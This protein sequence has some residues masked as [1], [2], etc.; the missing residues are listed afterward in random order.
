[1]NCDV[2]IVGAGLVGASLAA[3]LIGSGLRVLM[4]DAQADESPPHS[5][6]DSRIYAI[7]PGSSDYL[8]AIG[9]WQG[10]AP[11]RL[12]RVEAME[13]HGDVEGAEIRF[14]A[15]QAGRAELCFIVESREIQRA[16][17]E[18]VQAE[19]AITTA[20]ATRPV[21][22]AV[23]EESAGI[24]LSDG[25]SIEARLVVGADG[26]GSWVRD[27][28]GIDTDVRPYGQHGV[29]ANFE[30]ERAH[31]AIARQ[32]FMRDGVLAL[33]PLPGNRVS[34][35]WSTWDA[36]AERLVAL[37]AADLARE[38]ETASHHELGALRLIT[39]ARAFPLRWQRASAWV[40][41]RLALIGDAAHCVHPL[42]GQG[43]NLGFHDA[44][45]LAQVL[46]A[47]GPQDDCGDYR[48]LRRYARARVEPVRLMQ[49]TTD[50]LQRLFNNQRFGLQW[51]R[52]T[53]LRLSNGVVPLK[54]FLVEQALG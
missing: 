2:V 16:L 30:T 9:A 32:W 19:D 22:L 26:A 51:L 1:M 46:A 36:L 3:G 39:P 48:L 35:V 43:V 24:E 27:A 8:R 7:S 15:Y 41:P 17:R 6:W 54:S 23:G 53:G 47:R 38:V 34:M 50:G 45:A 5:D 20:Y 25:R 31:A 18:R 14:S 40:R 21:A 42:A 49:A 28:A 10:I 4:L 11:Q 29:V 37:D 52:N 33:L 13:V 44:R 12:A